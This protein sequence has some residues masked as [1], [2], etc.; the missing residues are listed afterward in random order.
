M[1]AQESVLRVNNSIDDDEVGSVQVASTSFC[2]ME[3]GTIDTIYL[4]LV[5]YFDGSQ[6]WLPLQ[7]KH[8]DFGPIENN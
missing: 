4:I 6:E 7:K 8:L 1:Y 5:N 3:D 2:Y